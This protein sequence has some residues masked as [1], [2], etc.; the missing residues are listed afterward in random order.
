MDDHSLLHLEQKLFTL[1]RGNGKFDNEF[2]IE[3]VIENVGSWVIKNRKNGLL[4]N[5]R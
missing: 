1:R 3:L 2:T 5:D 4:V